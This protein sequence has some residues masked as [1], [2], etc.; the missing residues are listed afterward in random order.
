MHARQTRR[1]TQDVLGQAREQEQEEDRRSALVARDGAVEL[2]KRVPP[3]EA[4]QRGPTYH[5]GKPEVEDR[6]ECDAD[7][8]VEEP[9]P[10]PED[11]ASGEGRDLAGYDGDPDLQQR[12]AAPQQPAPQPPP[13]PHP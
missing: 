8:G 12:P 10:R 11:I 5:A 2:V 13:A 6:A 4:L 1:V 7:G 3:D 9:T